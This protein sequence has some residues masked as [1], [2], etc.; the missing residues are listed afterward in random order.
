M[1]HQYLGLYPASY[2]KHIS[3]QH[4]PSSLLTVLQLCYLV[5]SLVLKTLTL[6]FSYQL[7]PVFLSLVTFQLEMASPER[8]FSWFYIERPHEPILFSS[9]HSFLSKVIYLQL[10]TPIR[11]DMLSEL[12]PLILPAP[13]T[14]SDHRC[15]INTWWMTEH[16]N[17][18][19]KGKRWE[20]SSLQWFL[21]LLSPQHLHSGLCI[22]KLI[23]YGFELFVLLTY[24]QLTHICSVSSFRL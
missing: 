21:S 4:T 6:G 19:P 12:L 8:G 20:N 13:R 15:S 16:I 9:Q 18:D 11:A 22:W 1:G 3:W 2:C 14:M 24:Y 23:T 17:K 7:N 5:I 10:P